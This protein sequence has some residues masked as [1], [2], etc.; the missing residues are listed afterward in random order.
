MYFVS[1]IFLHLTEVHKKVTQIAFKINDKSWC[2]K[3]A[4]S[5]S[6]DSGVRI[7]GYLAL[8]KVHNYRNMWL[9]Q[10]NKQALQVHVTLSWKCR[11]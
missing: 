5:Y 11:L 6:Y 7:N 2:V 10:L 3:T 1:M 8:L 4:L 9:I